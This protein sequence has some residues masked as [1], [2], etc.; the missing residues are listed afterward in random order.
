MV[1]PTAAISALAAGGANMVASRDGSLSVTLTPGEELPK[2]GGILVM[3]IP[4]WYASGTST[5]FNL[6][7]AT[8][9]HNDNLIAKANTEQSTSTAG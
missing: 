5:V 3:E 1:T 8:N 9:C 6:A 4:K 2:Y 7:P